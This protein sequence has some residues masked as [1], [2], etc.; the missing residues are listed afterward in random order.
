MTSF[1]LFQ[2]EK[3]GQSAKSAYH[4]AL[5]NYYSSYVESVLLS[6]MKNNEQHREYLYETLKTYLMLFNDDKF[7][8]EHVLGWFN[9]FFERQY[10]GELNQELREQLYAHTENFLSTGRQRLIYQHD[11]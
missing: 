4:Q 10:P 7:E 9:Y 6:E 8:R 11:Q 2:G 3:I 1:G 5:T